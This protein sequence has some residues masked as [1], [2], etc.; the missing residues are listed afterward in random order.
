M[1]GADPAPI[2]V[3]GDGPIR[4]VFYRHP[5]AINPLKALWVSVA[6]TT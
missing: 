2:F 5:L 6:F 1:A 4:Q 3:R